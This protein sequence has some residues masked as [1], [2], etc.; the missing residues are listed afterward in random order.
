M[1]QRAI[2]TAAL[3]LLLDHGTI[4]RSRGAD[5]FFFDHAARRRLARAVAPQVM[6]HVE[7]Y[8]NIY[9]VV[10][11]DGSVITTARRTRRLRRS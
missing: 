1:Q 6:Q 5:S 9:L 8:L 7:K 4:A 2:P 10:S 3:E 11:D